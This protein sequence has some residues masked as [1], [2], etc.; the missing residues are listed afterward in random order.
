MWYFF[1]CLIPNCSLFI[2]GNADVPTMVEKIKTDAMFLLSPNDIFEEF[3]DIA[4]DQ[5]GFP[6]YYFEVSQKRALWRMIKGK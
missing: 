1:I 2:L 4:L 3:G 5:Y 6:S